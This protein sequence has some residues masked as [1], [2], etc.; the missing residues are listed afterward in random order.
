MWQIFRFDYYMLQ[1]LVVKIIVFFKYRRVKIKVGES[2]RFKYLRSYFT[3]SENITFGNNVYV[4]PGANFDGIGGLTIN[5]N[6]IIAP[7]VTIMTRN[8]YFDGDDLRSLPFDNR[9]IIK[10]V[11]IE[12]NVW[13]GRQVIILPG[14]TIG[15]GA[16]IAAG[17]VVTKNVAPLT[18]VGGNP[19]KELKKRNSAIYEK[20][21]NENAFVYAKFSHKKEFVKPDA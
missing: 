4:G 3:N 18:V 12:K 15:E 11:K 10:S 16:V 17:S 13:I 2:S 5:D 14:I 19:A 21:A 20:L 7:E 8:H 9:V 6:V 1:K